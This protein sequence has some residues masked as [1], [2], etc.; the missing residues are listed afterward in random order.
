MPTLSRQPITPGVL[1]R[2]TVWELADGSSR[3]LPVELWLILACLCLPNLRCCSL[4]CRAWYE[5]LLSLENRWRLCLG[6][7]EHRH[8]NWPNQ[9]GVEPQSWREAFK[10]HYP[11]SKTWTKT[12]QDVQSSNCISRFQRRKGCQLCVSTGAEFSS[13]QAAF[14]T[15]SPYSHL[16]LLPGVHEEQSKVLLKVP[17]E[18]VMQGKLGDLAVLASIDQHCPAA[19]FCSVVFMLFFFSVL[20]KTSSGYVQFNSCN[21]ESGQLQ[22]HAPEMCQVKFRT[23][24]QSSIYFHSMAHCILGSCEFASDCCRVRTK[25]LPLCCGCSSPAQLSPERHW[26]QRQLADSKGEESPALDSDCSDSDSNSDYIEDAQ[27]AYKLPYQAHSLSHTIANV[28]ESRLQSNRL[29]T[30]QRDLKLKSLQQELQQDKEAQSLANSLQHCCI[31]QCLFRDRKGGPYSQGQAK[32]EG[33]IFR[34]LTYTVH[35]MQSSKVIILRNDIHHCKVPG[36]FLRLSAEGLIADSHIR[37]HCE[38]GVDIRKEANPVVLCNKIH[39]GL[40]SGIVVIGNRKGIIHNNQ[41]YGNKEAGIYIYNGNPAANYEKGKGPRHSN[42]CYSNSPFSFKHLTLLTWNVICEN[43]WGGAD[44]SAGGDPVIKN[45][46]I[47]SCSDSMVLG[48][49]GK[50]LIEGNTIYSNRGCGVW[51]MSSSL[52]HL[53]SHQISHNSI[54]GV[55]V[56]CHKDDGY[57][58]CQG[59]NE[60][61]QEKKEG[62]GREKDPGSEEYPAVRH[63]INVALVQLNSINYNGAACSHVKSSEMINVII[64]VIHANHDGRL[65]VVQSSQLTCVDSNSISCNSWGGMLV[66]PECQVEIRGNGIYEN[67]SHGIVSRG[68]GIITENDITGNHQCGLQLLQAADVK[69]R[70]QS[71]WNYGIPLFDEARVAVQQNLIFQGTSKKSILQPVSNAEDCIIQNNM[72]LTFRKRFDTECMLINSSAWPCIEG[73]A[74]GSCMAAGGQRVSSIATRVDGGCDNHGSIFCTIL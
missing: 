24:N 45:N 59:H 70:I 17:V 31:I 40:H 29:R 38:A 15:T 66:E 22:I 25:Q 46:L 11:A 63:P 34:D 50:S 68:E 8:P 53:I 62:T 18:V 23:F 6:C 67:H 9:P 74:P 51:M 56:F 57:L 13:L 32:L 27:A 19:C 41:I 44:I 14:G 69:N 30:L 73:S 58:P 49:H 39:S 54:Y 21:F 10:Q 20:Y 43:Q 3:E 48:K 65:V 12:M 26:I 28:M 64:G 61:F 52:P 7:L 1:S 47:S 5:L 42:Y 36:I 72:L 33:S 2:A 37:S 71:F 60:S 35:C 55:A 4:V 16:V